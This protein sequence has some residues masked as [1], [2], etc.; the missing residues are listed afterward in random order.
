MC[1]GSI[2]DVAQYEDF[3][4]NYRLIK[5][6]ASGAS[7]YRFFYKILVFDGGWWPPIPNFL[8]WRLMTS[9]PKFPLMEV[10]DLQSQISFDGGWWPPIPNFLL[11][12]LMTS[13]PKFPLM[14]VDDL[15]SQISL[16]STW[17]ILVFWL[18]IKSH[19]IWCDKMSNSPPYP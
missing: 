11:W 16:E 7:C 9:D 15:R 8:W 17:K 6:I 10:D 14:E 4:K 1:I 2:V 13:N 5:S 19:T 12:R 18:N 3:V